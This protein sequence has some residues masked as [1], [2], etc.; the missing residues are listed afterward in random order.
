MN[1]ENFWSTQRGDGFAKVASA[2]AIPNEN[3][4]E[5]YF[6]RLVYLYLYLAH[7]I[8]SLKVGFFPY[9]RIPTR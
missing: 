8:I 5:R 1:I 2:T 9:I 6:I 4:K 7:F 3:N